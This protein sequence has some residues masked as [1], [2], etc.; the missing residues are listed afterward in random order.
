[1]KRACLSAKWSRLK[2]SHIKSSNFNAHKSK[3]SQHK[4]KILKLYSKNLKS[5]PKSINDHFFM[6]FSMFSH[7]KILQKQ[8]AKSWHFI[9]LI[10][11]SLGKLGMFSYA[12]FYFFLWIAHLSFFPCSCWSNFSFVMLIIWL[13]II[14]HIFWKGIYGFHYECLKISIFFIM[15][16]W[17]LAWYRILRS[18][19]EAGKV[20][21]TQAFPPVRPWYVP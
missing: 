9:V 21:Q 16:D 15:H 6:S 14:C 5:P 19:R 1:M 11:I 20:H 10:Y 7:F 18:W 3:I 17:R 12:Y 4:G 13:S 8:W 2:R